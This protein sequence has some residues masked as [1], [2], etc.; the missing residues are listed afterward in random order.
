R[1]AGGFGQK[2]LAE[3]EHAKLICF[4]PGA[5]PPDSIA[6]RLAEVAASVKPPQSAKAVWRPE[7]TA[8]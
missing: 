8:S 2:G 1:K 6:A 7:M 5:K 4:V 3:K